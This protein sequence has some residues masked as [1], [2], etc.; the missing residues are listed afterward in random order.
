MAMIG[1]RPTPRDGTRGFCLGR[2][3][4][5]HLEGEAEGEILRL[6]IEHSEHLYGVC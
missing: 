3:G 4:M 5:R 2:V 1:K 6:L